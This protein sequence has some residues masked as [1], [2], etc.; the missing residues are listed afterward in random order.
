MT[1]S[2]IQG[3]YT[4]VGVNQDAEK[5]TYKGLLSL[6]VNATNQ[7]L[8][9]WHINGT[10]KQVGTGFF[11]NNILV[12]NFKYKG[13]DNQIYKGVVV[14]KCLTKDFFEGFW[15]EDYGDSMYLGEEKC[16]RILKNSVLVN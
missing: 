4:I 16:F 7:V 9:E 14:Y 2:D 1:I 8:A 5:S 10:Q 12:I 6:Q 3:D 13:D 15:S 11:K